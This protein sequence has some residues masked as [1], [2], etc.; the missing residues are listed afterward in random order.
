VHQKLAE[1]AVA[2]PAVFANGTVNVI[3]TADEI[4]PAEAR[5]LG[6]Y[7]SVSAPA[8]LRFAIMLLEGRCEMVARVKG[9][10]LMVGGWKG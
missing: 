6:T 4:G 7:Y 10:V 3:V 5:Q 1:L 8:Y 9:T 2:L